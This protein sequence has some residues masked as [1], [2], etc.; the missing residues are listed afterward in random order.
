MQVSTFC[1]KLELGSELVDW[2]LDAASVPYGHQLIDL[3][4]QR[5]DRLRFC[6]NAGSFAQMFITLSG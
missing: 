3:L 6:R 5:D 4:P 2:Y 1:G